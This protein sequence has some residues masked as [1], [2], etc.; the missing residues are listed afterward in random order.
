P[1]KKYWG[2]NKQLPRPPHHGNVIAKANS[3]KEKLRRRHRRNLQALEVGE[4]IEIVA[5]NRE[6]IGKRQPGNEVF[7][8]PET[9]GE[10]QHWHIW[11]VC[12]MGVGK[13]G[14]LGGEKKGPKKNE[15]TTAGRPPA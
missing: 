4:H 9:G 3:A 14:F 13:G 8:P 5:G 1:R 10:V 7:D 12:E 6:I 15:R 2:A 11:R